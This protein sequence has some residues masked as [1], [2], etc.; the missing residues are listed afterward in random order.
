MNQYF[1]AIKSSKYPEV[2]AV[3]FHQH[4]TSAISLKNA[5]NK[6]LN[7]EGLYV[8]RVVKTSKEHNHR[9]NM[10]SEYMRNALN[11]I[12]HSIEEAKKERKREKRKEKLQRVFGFLMKSESACY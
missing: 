11:M 4:W 8:A 9:A 1:V 3:W 6:L 10:D 7:D 5:L 2:D 12:R